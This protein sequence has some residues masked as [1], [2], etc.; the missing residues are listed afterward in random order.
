MRSIAWDPAS[1]EEISCFHGCQRHITDVMYL[2]G[3]PVLHAVEE[4]TRFFS[5]QFL[6]YESTKTVWETFLD[7]WVSMYAGLPHAILVDQGSCFAR[8]SATIG[9]L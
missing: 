9:A 7:F 2:D 3:K 1:S 4:G 5:A 6:K 8:A